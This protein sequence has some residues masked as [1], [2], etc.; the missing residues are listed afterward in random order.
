MWDTF[1]NLHDK[2]HESIEEMQKLRGLR[3]W[4]IH[5]LEDGPKNGVEIMD[6]IQEHQEKFH[7]MHNISK[8]KHINHSMK[9]HSSRPSPGS[10]Y[11]IL[12]KMVD[13]GLITKV[14]D[15]KYELTDKGR[16]ITSKLFGNIR[17]NIKPKEQGAFAVKNALIEID[18]YV[19]YLEDI[20]NEKLILHEELIDDIC[21][22]MNNIR[23]SIHGD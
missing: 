2:F 20:K 23:D 22:R 14:D 7:K 6:A 9:H 13:E 21:S 19:S 4:I 12:K 18:S 3:I 10:V 5:V 11:P 17:Q 16:D 8:N 1:K 15:G